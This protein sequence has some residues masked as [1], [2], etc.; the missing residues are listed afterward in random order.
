M[1]IPLYIHYNCMFSEKHRGWNE[2]YYSEFQPC[3]HSGVCLTFSTE[4]LCSKYTVDHNYYA[5][6]RN[7]L[8]THASDWFMQGG[9]LHNLPNDIE[10]KYEIAEMVNECVQPSKPNGRLEVVPKLIS[11]LRQ[12]R[13]DYF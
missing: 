6:C 10:H 5:A 9:L 3:H 4:D 12:I 7:V 11:A 8:S 2:P 13:T 1:M